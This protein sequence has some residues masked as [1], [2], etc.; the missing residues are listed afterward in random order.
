M[1]ESGDLRHPASGK[2]RKILSDLSTQLKQLHKELLE[3]QKSEVEKHDERKYGPFD[4][5]GMT[6]NDKRF[7]W[8]RPLSKLIT[9]IDIAADEETIQTGEP[10]AIFDEAARLLTGTHPEFSKTYNRFLEA[11]P[12]MARTQGEVTKVLMDLEP[13]LSK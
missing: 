4:L 9:R 13:L 7:E 2:I 1:S 8:L 5:L 11:N 12:P 6:L 3:L 10:R